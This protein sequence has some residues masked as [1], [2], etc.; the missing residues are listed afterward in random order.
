MSVLQYF[1]PVLKGIPAISPPIKQGIKYSHVGEYK[2]TVSLFAGC[3]MNELYGD[4]HRKTIQILR[5]NGYT[6][7][8]PHN[9]GCCGALHHHAGKITDAHKFNVQNTNAFE[10]CDSIIVNSA[11][12]GAELKQS[13]LADKVNDI[14]E[15][16]F[17][18]E[19]KSPLKKLEMDA[20]FDSP[21]HLAHAQKISKEP[22][23]ILNM[24]IEDL[25]D[26]PQSD[27][28]CGSA[29]S[30]TLEHPQMSENILQTK[31][32]DI[33]MVM[34]AGSIITANPGCQI[35]LEKGVQ[36]HKLNYEVLHIV[37]IIHHAYMQ[38]SNYVDM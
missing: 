23:S 31:V 24:F 18:I 29:G 19:L 8:I 5:W 1:I 15:F 38:D 37:D 12:C 2:G 25:Y 6:V 4:I 14:N 32:D 28:C 11:G 30:Y 22:Q 3:I 21:C 9:Q 7:K 26:F 36:Q 27:I 16:L 35:Q 10:E 13:S 34:D 33:K 17:N 20:V